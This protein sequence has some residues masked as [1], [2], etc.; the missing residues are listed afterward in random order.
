MCIRDSLYAG[1]LIGAGIG[2]VMRAGAST[3]G[4]DIPALILNLSL[5]HISSAGCD[6]IDNKEALP[7]FPGKAAG[8]FCGTGPLPA[9]SLHPGLRRPDRP[10]SP[11]SAR[12]SA[13][14][15]LQARKTD[16]S[17]PYIVFSPAHRLS[18]IHIL[19]KTQ[20]IIRLQPQHHFSKGN[21]FCHLYILP[22][23]PAC[24]RQSFRFSNFGRTYKTAPAGRLSISVRCV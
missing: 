5:I 10:D 13:S 22:F 3:G 11:G 12:E 6:Y 9:P 20:I 17:S 23:L 14:L 24:C 4:M 1:L 19:H 18:L 7:R 8:N 16:G 21:Y 2:L 15:S